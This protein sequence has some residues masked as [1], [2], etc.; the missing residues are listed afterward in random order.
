MINLVL[1]RD[2]SRSLIWFIKSTM[3]LT[4]I[5][6]QDEETHEAA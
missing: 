1:N 5:L 6:M 4:K 2:A 3:E